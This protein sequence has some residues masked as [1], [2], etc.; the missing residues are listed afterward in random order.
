MNSTEIV[1]LA[2]AAS[3]V[4]QVVADS[5]NE[6]ALAPVNVIEVSV[7]AAVP[8]FFTVTT[9]AAVVAPTKVVAKVRLVGV[10]VTTGVPPTTEDQLFT[11]LF[12][13]TDPRPVVR[14]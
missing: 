7:K 9:C 3:E 10:K 6:V 1:Q 11:R 2:A 13:F 4:P 12:A 14:S 5:T 8:E